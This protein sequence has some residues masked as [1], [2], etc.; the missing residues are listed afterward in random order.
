MTN[1]SIALLVLIK[2]VASLHKKKSWHDTYAIISIFFFTEE[3]SGPIL[4]S[5]EDSD[6]AIFEHKPLP[7]AH[8]HSSILLHRTLGGRG[9]SNIVSSDSEFETENYHER[10]HIKHNHRSHRHDKDNGNLIKMYFYPNVLKF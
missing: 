1:L 4:S 2:W 5:T 10:R 7:H 6:S 3:S 9:R 8:R